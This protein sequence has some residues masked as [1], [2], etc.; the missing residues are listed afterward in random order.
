[1]KKNIAIAVLLLILAVVSCG[2]Y[3]KIYTYRED[4]TMCDQ[5]LVSMKRT[6]DAGKQ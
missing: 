6:H 1:M 4:L 5:L 3:I 2:S